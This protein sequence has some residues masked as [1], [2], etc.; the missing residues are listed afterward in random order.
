MACGRAGVWESGCGCVFKCFLFKIICS[1][2][3]VFFPS[4]KSLTKKAFPEP[5]AEFLVFSF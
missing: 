5:L 3:L 2:I 4:P 1:F